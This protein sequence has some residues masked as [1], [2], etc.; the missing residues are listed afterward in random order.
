[1]PVIDD[2]VGKI[3]LEDDAYLFARRG[4]YYLRI[5]LPHRKQYI[6]SL[7]VK[8]ESQEKQI[9]AMAKAK[10]I[11]DDIYSRINSDLSIEKLTIP[12]LCEQFLKDGRA[13]LKVNLDSGTEIARIDGGRGAWTRQNM[14]LFSV[15]INEHILPFFRKRELATRD[16][17]QINQRDI[18][19][20]IR[21][22]LEKFPEEAPATFAKRNITMR[23]LFKLAQRMGERFTPPQ[24]ADIPKE[25]SKRRRPEISEDQY[26]EL[27]KHV[28]AI[29]TKEGADGRT[30]WGR[31][32]KYAYMFYGWLESINHT[33]IRPY[34]SLKNA[35]KMEHI[36]RQIDMRGNETLTLQRYE[37]NHSYVAVASPYWKKTLDRLEVFYKPF[38]ITND[39]EYLFVHPETYRGD[40]VEKGEPI[41]NFKGQW[42]TALKHLGWNEGKTQQSER[43]SP[44]GIRHRFAGRKLI[45]NEI[46]PI[47]LSQIMGT[48]LKMISDIYLHYS[49]VANYARLTKGDLDANIDVD[50][51][52]TETGARA[53]SVIE[54]SFFHHVHYDANPDCIVPP[55]TPMTSEEIK[56][57]LKGMSI[58]EI[59]KA[60]SGTRE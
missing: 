26:I 47:E 53:G 59:E 31:N 49:S 9:E 57:K 58:D 16:I 36:Q 3:H 10:S 35:I 45:E 29:Y 5:N 22:R 51:F 60:A 30:L 52:D 23:H 20:W 18:D 50:F 46:T 1:M 48:S 39:R 34:T 4:I 15:S 21:W 28:R 24:I 11:Y 27:L 56:T 6:R 2:S 14:S 43:I 25:I 13:G 55:D 37:K 32:Q 17:T 44:Y 19:N 12:K 7:K 8:V 40:K 41:I 54:N 42:T 38:G 33:G